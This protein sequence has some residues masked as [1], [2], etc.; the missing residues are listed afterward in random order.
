MKL[1]EYAILFIGKKNKEGDY[2]REPELLAFEL[3]LAKDD[4]QATVIA[5]RA[6]PEGFMSELDRVTI[7]VRPF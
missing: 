2:T 6:I 3:I 4:A 5:N 7:A 1:Y